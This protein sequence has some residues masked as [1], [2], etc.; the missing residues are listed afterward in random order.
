MRAWT[1][2]HTVGSG[3]QRHARGM[4]VDESS[5]PEQQLRCQRKRRLEITQPEMT[6][7]FPLLHRLNIHIAVSN[8]LG[9]GAW[10]NGIWNSM[11]RNTNTGV[12]SV[13]TRNHG[14]RPDQTRNRAAGCNPRTTH[15]PKL[16]F[17]QTLCNARARVL[18]E[19]HFCSG[20]STADGSGHGPS[21]V[22][23]LEVDRDPVTCSHLP[24]PGFHNNTLFQ[25]HESPVLYP[26][27]IRNS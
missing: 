27:P 11:A 17:F 19:R 23:L 26:S 25:P 1:V 2:L 14:T 7:R 8:K 22:G 9:L 24:P 12:V 15:P 21:Q 4:M 20:P 5:S 13:A 3:I 10:S 18:I 6:K 16:F